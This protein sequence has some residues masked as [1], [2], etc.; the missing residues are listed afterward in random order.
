MPEPQPS[1]R[2]IEVTLDET[3]LAAP[4]PEVEQERRVAIF[5]LLEDNRFA[6]PARDGREVPPGPYRLHL[7]IRERRLVF[8]IAAE[9][10][11]VGEFHLS[12]TPFNQVVKD[13]F[14]I[15]ESYFDA[16]KRLPPAQ[17]EAIDMGRRGIHDEGSRI[18]L[19]RLAGKVETD[20]AT[21]RR[22]FTLIC[23]LI[24]RG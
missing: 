7:A 18:L 14:Q 15:C 10:G 19:E 23:A 11:R 13:Y 8:E 3:G 20:M 12:L 9:G 24:V 5:D 4:T 2:L 22:L 6:L 21:A 1:D 17:I 16:V